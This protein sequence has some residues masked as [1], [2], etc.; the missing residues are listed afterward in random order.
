MAQVVRHGRHAMGRV[1]IRGQGMGVAARE[2]VLYPYDFVNVS[3]HLGSIRGVGL[4]NN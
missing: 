4:Q 2:R 1:S 3:D